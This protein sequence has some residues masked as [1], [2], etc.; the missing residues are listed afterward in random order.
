MKSYNII[1]LASE[2]SKKHKITGLRQGE[3]IEEVLI[4]DSEQKNAEQKND[5]WIIKQY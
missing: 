1:D 2:I 3:K 4:T 5:M